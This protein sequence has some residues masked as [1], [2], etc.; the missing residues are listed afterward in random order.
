MDDVNDLPA[1]QRSEHNVSGV[2]SAGT[3]GVLVGP[4][5]LRELKLGDP[6][7]VTGLLARYNELDVPREN[8][9]A[10]SGHLLLR[11][12]S[13][14]VEAGNAG[15]YYFTGIVPR[16]TAMFHMIFWDK[17]LT[18]DR[19]EAAKLVLS[20]AFRLFDLRRVGAAVVESN[21]P[22]RKTLQKIGFTAEGVLRKAQVLNGEYHDL[23]L[24]GLLSEETT[25]PLLTTSLD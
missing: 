21:I 22:L 25:W 1:V 24:Y 6:D 7:Q 19:R 3:G 17:H 16:Q 8:I 4:D 11:H 2:R 9:E 15:L 12:D 14:F 20:A 13:W 18:A 10:F 5:D 23:H